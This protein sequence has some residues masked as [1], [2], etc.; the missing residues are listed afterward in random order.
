MDELDTLPL[1]ALG[2]GSDWLKNRAGSLALA[3]AG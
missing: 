1:Q 3:S 2:G